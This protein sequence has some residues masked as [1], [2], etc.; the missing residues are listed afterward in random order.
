MNTFPLLLIV[1]GVFTIA[2]RYYSALLA[3]RAFM[4]DDRNITPAHRFKDGHNYVPSPKWVVFGHHFAAI[5]GAGPLVGPTLA[6]QFGY[7][8]GLIWL[9][10]G[11]VL[12]GAVQDLTV[13]IGSLRHNGKSLP[14]IVQREIGPITGLFAMIA[15]VLI[16]IVAMAGLAI[17]VV[18]ALSQSA[19]GIFT[20]G[21][22][23]PIAMVM[24][25]WMFK[26]NANKVTVIGP[27]IFGV[28]ALIA[29]LVGGHWM[30][31][32]SFAHLLLFDSHEIVLLLCGYGF[33]ASVL[34]V[35]LLLE[36]RDYLSTYVKLG[37]LGALI[38]GVLIVHPKLQF[39][40]F[41][42]YIHGGGPVIPGKLFPF[43]FVTIACGAI[44]GFHALVS[45]GT[46]PKLINKETDARF[47]GYGAML[48]ESLV[49]VL[50][51]IAACSMM[52]G[53]YF[54]INVSP[55][56]FAG[57]GMHAVNL[58]E[59]SREIG[60]QLAGRTGGAVSLAIGMAQIFRGIPGMKALMGYWYH[61]AI[62]FEALFILTTI[63]AGTRVARYV[64]QELMGKIYKPLGRTNWL[65]SS[66][67]ATGFIVF[68][69]GYLI[70]GGTIATIWPLFGT[71][72]QLLAS[73]ALATMTTWLVNH[74]K[75]IYAW[76]TLL[77]AL[78]VLITTISA[79]VLSIE[80]IFWPMAM[81]NVNVVQGW[82]ESGLMV[83]FII[84][85]IV[86]V[87]S[88]AVR[89]VR[90]LRGVPPPSATAS[91][92]EPGKVSLEPAAPF[93]CC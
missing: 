62:L 31:N 73:I 89:C 25:V 42:Q 58:P 8:P 76:C 56:V 77:P 52:P 19:W 86:I 23:I 50:A 6:A 45:S 60:E 55:A 44:S 61:Y 20:I 9:V 70:W 11:A 18:N 88:A 22:T 14:Y 34:P 37:T 81:S 83:A 40:A 68:C 26:S 51:L 64:M 80:N 91:E 1:L 27:S 84:G 59:F 53:D 38:A 57:L 65:P 30:A 36:P 74:G 32:S 5:A 63:D 90:T 87:G 69:W 41:T 4:L 17:I 33:F 49:G 16:L 29:S 71:A 48:G 12:A 67:L 92:T 79:G 3:T 82:I 2:Y 46:T 43:L 13:L 93:R 54:A 78:F 47:I 15:V 10:A 72:N 66:L 28:S 75:A 21:M 35:W 85:A 24:G 39:P 7:A